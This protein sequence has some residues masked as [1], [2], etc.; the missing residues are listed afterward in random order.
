MKKIIIIGLF[1]LILGCKKDETLINDGTV[2][3][4]PDPVALIGND[5]IQLNWLNYSIFNM[6]LLPYTYV[7]PD[8]FEIYVST[9][10]TDNF[11]KLIELKNDGKYSY[12]I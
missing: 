5:Q 8:N 4:R 3:W 9:G 11:T 1:L 2:I 7:D 10:T 6:I 12:K